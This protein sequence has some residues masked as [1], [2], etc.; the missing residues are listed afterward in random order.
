M[1]SNEDKVMEARLKKVARRAW[2]KLL[3][4]MKSEPGTLVIESD[5]TQADASE[6]TAA[7]IRAWLFRRR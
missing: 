4:S 1:D 6:E 3:K 5:N 2:R 7:E